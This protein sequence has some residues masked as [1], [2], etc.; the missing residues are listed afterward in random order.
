MLSL[1][2]CSGFNLSSSEVGFANFPGNCYHACGICICIAQYYICWMFQMILDLTSPLVYVVTFR[3]GKSD[4]LWA[5]DVINSPGAASARHGVVL[6]SGCDISKLPLSPEHYSVFTFSVSQLIAQ[7]FIMVGT[8]FREWE[9]L[10]P[11]L[12]Y[13]NILCFRYP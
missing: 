11:W 8:Y 4:N 9:I 5:S 3:S 7:V 12:C 1:H 2:W 10:S 6:V 13:A